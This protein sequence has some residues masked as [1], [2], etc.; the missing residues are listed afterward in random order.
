MRV[1][2]T[3]KQIGCWNLGKWQQA[4]I[5]RL[6]IDRCRLLSHLYHIK[7][8]Q[9]SD[10]PL[11]TGVRDPVRTLQNC[12]THAPERIRLWPS[13]VDLKDKLWKSTEELRTKAQF[14]KNINILI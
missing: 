9:T 13:G 1:F 4:T 14:I 5:F 10:C 11:G 2:A 6:R 7:I 8:F 12:S 3:A